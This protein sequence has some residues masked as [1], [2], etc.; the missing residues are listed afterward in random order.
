LNIV[1]DLILEMMDEMVI[2]ASSQTSRKVCGL[3]KK[4][5]EKWLSPQPG[6]AGTLVKTHFLEHMS[7]HKTSCFNYDTLQI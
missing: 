4:N 2:N 7:V 6:G 5:F 1:P 3:S